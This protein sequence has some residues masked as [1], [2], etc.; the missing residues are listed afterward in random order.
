M[1]DVYLP[2][3]SKCKNKKSCCSQRCIDSLS[4]KHEKEM[5]KYDRLD[6]LK[7]ELAE[8]DK[9]QKTLQNATKDGV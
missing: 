7:R 2:D 9:K 4:K 5:H 6:F 8:M 3:C 1:S